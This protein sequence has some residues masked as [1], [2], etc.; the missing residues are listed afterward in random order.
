[1]SDAA[2]VVEEESEASE[3]SQENLVEVSSEPEEMPDFKIFEK[4]E[5][6]AETV[7]AEPEAEEPAKKEESEPK[8]KDDTWSARVRKDRELRQR[9]IDFKRREQ[10]LIGRESKVSQLEGARE[11]ILNDPN[12]FFKSVGLDP[13]KFYQDW[14]ERLATGAESPSSELQLSSTQQEL[15][16]LKEQLSR[17]DEVER[18][19]Q[20]EAQRQQVIQAYDSKISEFQ[21]DFAD[22]F[23]LTA[24]RCSVEDI[25]EGMVTYYQ[26]TGVELGFREAFDTIEKG[27]EEEERKAFDDP[28]VI[29]RFKKHHNLQEAENN[30]GAQAS[31]TL[32]SSMRVPPTKKSPEDMTHDEIVAHY[33]GKL[34]T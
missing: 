8:K 10:E 13:L 20:L 15:K 33:E 29:A 6:E 12:A 32:S 14:S 26:Q 4:D 1:M 24:K 7:E 9:E 23:P 30:S 16:E 21:K 19:N 11:S 2:A 17:R 18:A 27:L 34:F 3:E 31:R 28:L 25:R 22:E 5:P